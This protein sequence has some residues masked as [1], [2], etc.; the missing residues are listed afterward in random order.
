MLSAAV[1]EKREVMKMYISTV[2]ENHVVPEKSMLTNYKILT[3]PETVLLRDGVTAQAVGAGEMKTRILPGDGHSYSATLT[4]VMHV[5]SISANVFSVLAA[6]RNGKPVHFDLKKCWV[7]SPAGRVMSLGAFNG[8]QYEMSCE[9]PRRSKTEM[10]QAE[11]LSQLS[12]MSKKTLADI[13]KTLLAEEDDSVNAAAVT[14]AT[15]LEQ[16]RQPCEWKHAAETQPD[17]PEMSHI[18]T[19]ANLH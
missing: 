3:P 1:A 17:I 15:V 2:E 12:E 7:K 4:G 10:S 16:K 14:R 11:S 8:Q 13:L 19:Q 5:P 18:I 9:D 6:A